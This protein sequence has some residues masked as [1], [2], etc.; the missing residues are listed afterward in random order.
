MATSMPSTIVPPSV[1]TISDD[2]SVTCRNRNRIQAMANSSKP[3]TMPATMSARLTLRMMN[4]REVKD[5][6]QRGG[7]AGDDPA[8][9]R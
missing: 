2:R 3:T 5:A 6:P 4:G 1:T 8:H 9:D 7:P